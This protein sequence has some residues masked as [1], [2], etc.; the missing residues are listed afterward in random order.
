MSQEEAAKRLGWPQSVI[1]KIELGERRMDVIELLHYSEVV[2]FDGLKLLREVRA[3]LR[4]H[5]S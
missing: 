4:E 5:K 1:A 2:G 3:L